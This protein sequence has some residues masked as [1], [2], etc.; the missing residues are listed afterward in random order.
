MC[1]T[2]VTVKA[3]DISPTEFGVLFT[4]Y[5]NRFVSVAVS[6]VRNRPDAE[7]LV[8]EAFTKFWDDRETI[9][10]YGPP[11]AYIRGSVRNKCLDYLRTLV[12]REKVEQ[13]LQEER[14]RAIQVEMDYL[15]EED[16]SWMFE[17]EVQET[18]RHFL[19][20]IP[21]LRR[22]IFCAVK[23]DGLTYNETAL[24]LG[25]SPRKVK[26]EISIVLNDLRKALKGSF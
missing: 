17:P 6:Y 10:L 13:T 3:T 8:A 26:R 12:T 21:D 9:E 23:Y 16:S 1:P 5:R 22:Q 11:E 2:F 25:I 19:N 7:D 20:E 15:R 18:F 14:R 4:R 24:R